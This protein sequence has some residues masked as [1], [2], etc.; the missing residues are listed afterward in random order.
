MKISYNVKE[1]GED[2][3]V[4]RQRIR[5]TEREFDKLRDIVSTEI[6]MGYPKV[7]DDLESRR[8]FTPLVLGG[9]ISYLKLTHIKYFKR[10]KGMERLLLDRNTFIFIDK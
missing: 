2:G 5:V 10:F 7:G 6:A 9:N 3:T 8:F 1:I 4:Y